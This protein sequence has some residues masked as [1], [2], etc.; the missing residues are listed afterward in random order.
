MSYNAMYVIESVYYIIYTMA[1]NVMEWNLS[2]C[3]P[4]QNNIDKENQFIFGPG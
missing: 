1:C 2:V 3:T 4:W